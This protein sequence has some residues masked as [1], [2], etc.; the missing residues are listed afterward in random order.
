MSNDKNDFISE[1]TSVTNMRVKGAGGF[2]KVLGS[3]TLKW[4]IDDDD[5][6]YHDI[7]I[8]E[9]LYI[10]GLSS[11]LLCPQQWSKQVKDNFPRKRGTWCAT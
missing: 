10:P 9:A 11:C 2:L 3:G 8:K 5:G 1:I 4:T 6:K 7:I